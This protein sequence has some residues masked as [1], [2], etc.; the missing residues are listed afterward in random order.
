MEPKTHKLLQQAG[1]VVT[2]GRLTVA[3]EQYLKVHELE[4]DDS[5]I[6][7]TIAD[8]YTRLENKNEALLWYSKLAE[9]FEYRELTLNAIAT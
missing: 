4:P 6:I 1:K 8:L 9:T 2:L 3:L 5:T 7:N